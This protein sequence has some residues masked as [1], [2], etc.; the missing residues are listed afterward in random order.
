MS[1]CDEQSKKNNTPS[2]MLTIR[3]KQ[4]LL[5][6]TH[7][8]NILQWL[9]RPNLIIH[10]HNA[11]QECILSQRAFEQFHIDQPRGLFNG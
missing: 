7:L 11:H 6:P 2:H 3:M 8:A 10:G 4:N 9:S 1:K 5:L